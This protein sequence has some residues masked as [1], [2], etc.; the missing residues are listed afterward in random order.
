MRWNKS[1]KPCALLAVSDTHREKKIINWLKPFNYTAIVTRFPLLLMPKPPPPKKNVSSTLQTDE[2]RPTND[3]LFSGI[4]K[5][6]SYVISHVHFYLRTF[7]P[8]IKKK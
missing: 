8:Y 7:V 6:L 1:P 5:Q 4:K 2:R 3:G